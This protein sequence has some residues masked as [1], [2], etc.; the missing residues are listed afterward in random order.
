MV[1]SWQVFGLALPP[2]ATQLP[3]SSAP[4]ALA[5]DASVRKRLRE[6]LVGSASR[7]RVL[8]RQEQER[9]A[10][11][12]R[13]QHERQEN[14][15]TH[16]W[17][18]GGEVRTVNEGGKDAACT[19]SG[20]A[21]S[22]LVP[23]D[24]MELDLAVLWARRVGRTRGSG[25]RGHVRESQGMVRFRPG[26][27]PDSKACIPLRCRPHASPERGV[28]RT[29]GRPAPA[30]RPRARS[31]QTLASTIPRPARSQHPVALA[32]RPPARAQ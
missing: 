7:A 9:G 5:N 14:G 15:E 4:I 27:G 21:R 1:R 10:A 19:R 28:A 30:K 16:R 2:G 31:E 22:R 11:A 26:S 25:R 12:D 3:G 29:K 32:Q 17:C 24:V 13:H 20:F 8:P 6:G 18:V 23:S